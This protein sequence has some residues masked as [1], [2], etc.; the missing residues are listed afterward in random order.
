M[1]CGGDTVEAGDTLL[2]YDGAELDDL[3]RQ[4]ELT[5]SAANYGYR[6]SIE[7]DN[8]NASEYKRSSE[9]LVLSTASWTRRTTMWIT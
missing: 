9:A 1:S 4:A 3:Y 5:G 2:T 7:K 6:D 8:K